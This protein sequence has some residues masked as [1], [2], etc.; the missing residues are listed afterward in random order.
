M[1]PFRRVIFYAYHIALRCRQ[2]GCRGDANPPCRTCPG[3]PDR[4]P[5]RQMKGDIIRK[6]VP[7]GSPGHLH[8][9]VRGDRKQP[10]RTVFPACG[11]S[12][13]NTTVPPLKEETYGRNFTLQDAGNSRPGLAALPGT[14]QWSQVTFLFNF[15]KVLIHP[16]DARERLVPSG[17]DLTVPSG[18]ICW[19]TIKKRMQ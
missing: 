12:D 19:K 2:A 14:T 15:K 8:H 7:V 11:R 17:R 18:A 1:K 9:S 10:A 13:V 4:S 3:G 6:T 16:A 5:G